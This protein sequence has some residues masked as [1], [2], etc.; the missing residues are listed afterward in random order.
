[1]QGEPMKGLLSC[2]TTSGLEA[3]PSLP[4]PRL[5]IHLLWNLTKR[6]G[7]GAKR[8]GATPEDLGVTPPRL[9]KNDLRLE[10]TSENNLACFQDQCFTCGAIPFVMSER[11]QVLCTGPTLQTNKVLAPPS[12]SLGPTT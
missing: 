6:E 2:R 10:R 12:S 9:V 5:P 8:G 4:T 11:A 1:M 7:G 3:V